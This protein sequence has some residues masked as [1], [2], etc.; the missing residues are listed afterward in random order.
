LD[1]LVNLLS[2]SKDQAGVIDQAQ[3]S[4]TGSVSH[5][6][7]TTV[8][9]PHQASTFPEPSPGRQSGL[10]SSEH[11]T[12]PSSSTGFQHSSQTNG[13]HFQLPYQESAFLLLEFRTSMAH[14]FPFVVVPPEATSE[15][16]RAE[17][18][19]L[20]KAILTA[21]SCLKPSQQEAMGLELVEEF[22][23]RLLLKGEK[24]LDLLQSILI[25]LAWLATH[26]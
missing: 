17:R 5:T 24:S 14:Q 7:P 9:Q 13:T 22:S 23:T 18:P 6:S 8:H 2:K 16:L 26:S 21:A 25:Y 1:D 4:M 3:L 20:W 11:D 19:M 10:G 15:S 12:G